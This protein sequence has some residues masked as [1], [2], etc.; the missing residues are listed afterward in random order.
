MFLQKCLGMTHQC[1]GRI[2]ESDEEDGYLL[3]PLSS[4]FKTR[5]LERFSHL[6]GVAVEFRSFLV[7]EVSYKSEININKPINIL[8]FKKGG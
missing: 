5:P 4:E 6:L 3:K 1:Y 2:V 8:D 7:P